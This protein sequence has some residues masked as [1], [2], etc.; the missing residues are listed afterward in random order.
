MNL[1]EHST[2]G[3][4]VLAYENHVAEFNAIAAQLAAA[5]GN[6][7]AAVK[8]FMEASDDEQAV[9]I[10]ERLNELK[11][12]VE[13]LTAKFK[14]YAEQNVHVETLD[15]ETKA[16]L[17]AEQN[18]KR[19]EVKN[20]LK[21]FE[22]LTKTLGDPEIDAAMDEYLKEHPDPTAKRGPNTG[23]ALP[24]YACYVD[25]VV[26]TNPGHTIR[27]ENLSTAAPVLGENAESLGRKVAEAGGVEYSQLST[28]TKP[29]TFELPGGQDGV[30]YTVTVTPKPRKA[31]GRPA[32][33]PAEALASGEGTN[34]PEQ[35]GQPAEEAQ[36]S[37]VS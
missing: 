31:P 25:I 37:G 36:T 27:K 6:K 8:A 21:S 28:L 11:A 24:K 23:S 35:D 18:E 17:T 26:S 4:F 15:E 14:E 13:T 3:Q 1:R 16:K 34:T 29:V 32:S 22:I 7:D 9:K 30:T 5:D 33:S 2:F 19:K 12:Q 20:S 10:R